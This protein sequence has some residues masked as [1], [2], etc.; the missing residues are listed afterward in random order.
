MFHVVLPR[1]SIHFVFLV[2]EVGLR[3]GLA[4]AFVLQPHHANQFVGRSDPSTCR[5]SSAVLGPAFEPLLME[6]VSQP[7]WSR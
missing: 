3:L 4:E 7:V 1:G 5:V 6:L 2:D